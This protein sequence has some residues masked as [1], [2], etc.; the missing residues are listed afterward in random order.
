MTI[1]NIKIISLN[2]RGL[3]E[4]R[5]RKKVF[6]WLNDRKPEIIMLQETHSVENIVSNWKQ[7]MKGQMYFAHGSR[8]SKGVMTILKNLDHVVNKVIIDPDGRFL[9]ID[10]NISEKHFL[11]VNSY[12]P[13]EQSNHV[14]FLGKMLHTMR[15]CISNPDTNIIW[16]GDHNIALDINLDR[17]GGNPMPWNCANKTFKEL[18]LTFDLIDI[19]RVRNPDKREF[20]WRRYRP[21]LIQSRLD[22]FLTSD[23]LQADIQDVFSEPCSLTDHSAVHLHLGWEEIERGPSY[24]KFN[25]SLLNDQAYIDL[26]EDNFESWVLE[27]SDINDAGIKWDWLKYKIKQATI[28]YSK[29]KAKTRRDKIRELEEKLKNLEKEITN[30]PS[31]NIILEIDSTKSQLQDEYDYRLEGIIIRSRCNWM[32]YGEKNSKYFLQLEK[33]NQKRSQINKLIREDN[34]EVIGQD[35]INLEI[36][37]FYQKLYTS[38]IQ[39]NNNHNFVNVENNFLNNPNIPKLNEDKA[40]FCE[41]IIEEN[42]AWLALKKLPSHKTPGNDGLTSDFYKQFWHLIKNNL[43]LSLNSAFQK[44][45][46][47]TSQ[48]QGVI[49]LI[50]KK[51]KDRRF[52]QNWRPITLLNVDFKI[53]TKCLAKRLEKV[54]PDLIHETQTAFVKNRYIGDVIRLIEEIMN[55]TEELNIPGI[56]ITVDIQ[57]AFDC[58]E[59]SYLLKVLKTFNFLT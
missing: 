13:T 36:K 38:K 26:I 31:E 24:W 7:Q 54:L 3:G 58:L 52:I 51:G 10:I 29:E 47:S 40:L 15:D 1:S 43:I 23:C 39:R 34:T 44:G 30:N 33:S 17:H 42:E 41:G 18:M 20:T 19:W 8:N 32:E 27:G 57:K 14:T 53:A 2:V 56:L 22:Y 50:E 25:D 45:E 21:N 6:R 12:A 28:K 49:T 16:G 11:L 46:F 4:Y 55:Y 48:K 5:K 59:W 35:K 9:V 37:N